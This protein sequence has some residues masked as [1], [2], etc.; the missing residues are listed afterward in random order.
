M[1]KPYQIIV[2]LIVLTLLSACGSSPAPQGVK[3]GKPY[4]VAGEK[5]V[6]AYNPTYDEIGTASWYGPGFHGGHTANGERYDQND[7]TAAHRTLPLPSIVRV[8]NLDNGKSAI[9]RINDR[10]PFAHSR[11]I[12]LSR[13]AADKLGVIRTGTAKV[14]VQFL[15]Q[16]TREYVM[17]M[18]N[19]AQSLAALDAYQAAH[20]GNNKPQ[21][22]PVATNQAAPVN[23]IQTSALSPLVSEAV[24]A[25]EEE[26][27]QDIFAV[28]DHQ[29]PP[30]APVAKPVKA[31][32][33]NVGFYVQ[34]GT[35]KLKENASRLMAS[36]SNVGV[37]KIVETSNKLYRVVVGPYGTRQDADEI[38]NKLEGYGVSGA[39][40]VSEI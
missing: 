4:T 28:A 13:A 31:S 39:K 23:T 14:R 10:G 15:D 27:E 20:G 12:D 19:G 17:K 36:I 29:S 25:P 18:P 5:Y 38:I 30:P 34:A 21:D 1:K 26:P 3:I 11:I 22:Y 7:L 6:P 8:T 33:S 9:I 2:S 24:A 35:F 40:V 37:S 16:E 32:V